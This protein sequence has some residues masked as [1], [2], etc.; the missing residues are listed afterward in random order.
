MHE[1]PSGL[2]LLPGVIT[3]ARLSV[4]YGAFNLSIPIA[5]GESAYT[6]HR[7]VR[8]FAPED[9]MALVPQDPLQTADLDESSRLSSI[10]SEG[11]SSETISSMLQGHRNQD[12][13]DTTWIKSKAD[14]DTWFTKDIDDWRDLVA[15]SPSGDLD[16]SYLC[17]R[18]EA[19]DLGTFFDQEDGHLELSFDMSRMDPDCTFCSSMM[20]Y[21][22]GWRGYW[23]ADPSRRS[24]QRVLRDH[25]SSSVCGLYTIKHAPCTLGESQ[26]PKTPHD[27]DF[28]EFKEYL[29]C[30][31]SEHG[32][33]CR[34]RKMTP[35]DMLRVFNCTTRQVEYACP[36]VKYV[37]LSYVWGGV[38][39]TKERLPQTIEDAAIVTVELGY[40][41]LWVDQLCIDQNDPNKIVYIQQM[42]RIYHNAEVTIIA[43]A[44]DNA[45]YGIP[46]VSST[47]REGQRCF[48]VGRHLLLEPQNEAFSR[49]SKST[50]N[51]RGWTFQE[52]L[53]SS[54]RLVFTNREAYFSCASNSDYYGSEGQ[55]PQVHHLQRRYLRAHDQVRRVSFPFCGEAGLP[56]L[57]SLI[58]EYSSRNLT[59][60]S[61]VLDAFWAVF[62]MFERAKRPIYHIWGVPMLS[63]TARRNPKDPKDESCRD[64]F[65]Y[66]LSWKKSET[67]SH[68]FQRR[69]GFP[70]W[71]WTGWIGEVE[72]P[73]SGW[74]SGQGSN[75]SLEVQSGAVLSLDDFARQPYLREQP[76]RISQFICLD[77]WTFDV[78]LSSSNEPVPKIRAE[79][80]LN[81]GTHV[82]CDTE[83]LTIA[84]QGVDHESFEQFRGKYYTGILLRHSIQHSPPP[85]L[86]VEEIGDLAERI[87][88]IN[89]GAAESLDGQLVWGPGAPYIKESLERH[90]AHWGFVPA[91]DL[92]R[93]T[94]RKIR[95]R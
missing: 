27:I 90:S 48:K 43:A 94:Q 18:C 2:G 21:P 41:Y 3:L 25:R 79:V 66:G 15:P 7:T 44:G 91:Q 65:L 14:L 83:L 26:W 30:C 13:D 85:V 89:L 5:M 19:L 23:V 45:D 17:S 49:L 40:N 86:L 1:S 20:V 60:P 58:R 34:A 73:S 63:A 4:L 56:E 36:G 57:T 33:L 82:F 51:T 24:F 69:P 39:C 75:V 8:T 47:P 54:R 92:V 74:Y 32:D 84:S 67:S 72:Y 71:S 31:T 6:A 80:E 55:P 87:G 11:S 81:D 50:W 70:S 76:D 68:S 9:Q 78:R 52:R 28:Q 61:D 59:E 95:L 77:S 46:G 10:S 42:D 22:G 37:A 93:K 88:S 53:L 35:A 64:T 12:L 16:S 29:S 38:T 62:R